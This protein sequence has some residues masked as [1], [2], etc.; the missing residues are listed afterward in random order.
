MRRI[1]VTALFLGA[2]AVTSFGQQWEFGGMGGAGFLNNVNV[3]SSAGSATAGFKAGAAVGAFLGQNL[4]AHWSGELRYAYMQSD[5]HIQ[6]GGL[7]PTFT[8]SAHVLHYDLL[9]HT[10]RK[11]SRVQAFVA[12]GGGIKIFRATDP[13]L[14]EA[15]Q[16]N[17]QFGYMTRTQQLK[18]MGDVGAGL[19][20]AIGRN[21]YLRT[22]IRDYITPFPNKIIAPPVAPDPKATYGSILNDLVPMVGI[23]YEK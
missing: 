18:P 17:S 21:V 1:A 15:F 5:V 22:E 4:Y 2:F 3:S 6:S 23:S 8:A 10:N 13:G 19:R 20:F 11:G 9:Y 14:D 16:Q 12:A 7:D